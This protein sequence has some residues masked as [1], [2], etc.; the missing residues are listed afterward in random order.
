MI[1]VARSAAPGP[2][3]PD[4]MEGVLAAAADAGLPEAYRR[5]LETFLPNGGSA[6]PRERPTVR[7]LWSTPAGVRRAPRR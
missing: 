2:P 5:E 7:P 4:Y 3:K 6:E 1:Y